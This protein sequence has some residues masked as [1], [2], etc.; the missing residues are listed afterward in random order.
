[1]AELRDLVRGVHPSVLLGTDTGSG[2]ARVQVRS[3][4]GAPRK[5]RVE[6]GSGDIAVRPSR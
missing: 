4:P 3:D 1:M 6:T 2:D 5:L